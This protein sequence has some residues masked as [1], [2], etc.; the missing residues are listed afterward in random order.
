MQL[1][2]ETSAKVPDFGPFCNRHHKNPA[3]LVGKNVEP[4]ANNSSDPSVC[5]WPLV[6]QAKAFEKAG[7]DIGNRHYCAFR[8]LDQFGQNLEYLRF[9]RKGP[10]DFNKGLSLE[11]HSAK[12][13]S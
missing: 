10:F 13:G 9:G 1:D 2:A 11:S 12:L 5:Y 7:G 4:F 8:C 3:A 6:F